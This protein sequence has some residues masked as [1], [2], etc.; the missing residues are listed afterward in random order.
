MQKHTQMLTI[1]RALDR[2][3]KLNDDSMPIDFT[4]ILSDIQN[5]EKLT[6]HP[7]IYPILDTFKSYAK[8][9]Q[10]AQ[11]ISKAKA[12]ENQLGS[13][14]L[15]TTLEGR[16]KVFLTNRLFKKLFAFI[17]YIGDN[18]AITKALQSAIKDLKYPSEITLETLKVLNKADLDKGFKPI[19]DKEPR[20]EYKAH[21][22]LSDKE[23]QDQIKGNTQILTPKDTSEIEA[24]AS[25]PLIQNMERQAKYNEELTQKISQFEA[26]KENIQ[27]DIL[28]NLVV[29]TQEIKQNTELLKQLATQL[30]QNNPIHTPN[31]SII[32]AQIDNETYFITTD[33]NNITAIEKQEIQNLA[34][35]KTYDELMQ[36]DK[37]QATKLDSMYNQYVEIAEIKEKEAEKQLLL[38]YKPEVAKASEAMESNAKELPT[39]S[40]LERDLTQ[41]EIKETIDKWDLS[42]EANSKGKQRL[43]VSKV[44]QAE[45][46]ELNKHF[47]FKGKRDLTREIDSHQIIHTLKQ[48][49]DENIE[50]SRGQIAVDMDDI[51][52]YIDIVKN[53]DFKN[54]Q[55]NGKIVYAKQI[56]GHHIVLEEVLEGQDKIRFFDMWKQK[57]ELN[58]EVLLSHSQ[59]PNTSPSLNL[60]RHMPN[61][62]GNDSINTQINKTLQSNTPQTPKDNSDPLKTFE[63]FKDDFIKAYPKALEFHDGH[64]PMANYLSH[65]AK[66]E[67]QE[68]NKA[69]FN[70][71]KDEFSQV[72]KDIGFKQHEMKP[73]IDFTNKYDIEYSLTKVRE[74]LDYAQKH[75]DTLPQDQQ[76]LAKDLLKHKQDILNIYESKMP[77]YQALDKKR[78]L[79]SSFDN[80][81]KILGSDEYNLLKNLVDELYIPQTPKE[82]IKQARKS[83]KSVKETKELLQKHN[84]EI[85]SIRTEIR[86]DIATRQ[87]T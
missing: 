33:K 41:Q 80:N 13:G 63:Y 78:M 62:M 66:E 43:M 81:A 20:F 12:L 27:Q 83:G 21:T 7:E 39:K 50:K 73:V 61:N 30:T 18:A 45:A 16:I 19:K 75:Y 85:Q 42:P 47:N 14:A 67:I 44:S 70:T 64:M 6:L 57:G 51:S 53:N 69:L 76:T 23:L 36:R 24:I 8:S 55:D 9:Y 17:P 77:Q 26:N 82:I 59:R 79:M 34:Q 71:A 58:K 60:E 86:K 3:V 5:L 56:N 48:H 46:E 11:E 4:K 2:N 31:K 84:K 29:A 37:N 28:N 15:A 87:K 72:L 25:N 38:E 35:P 32:K 74:Y 22:P 65:Y 10:F 40:N 68:A 1:L 52:N 49:G 54:I